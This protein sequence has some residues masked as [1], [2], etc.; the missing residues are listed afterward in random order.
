MIA[1]T[2]GAFGLE[3]NLSTWATLG[4]R[5]SRELVKVLET[6]TANDRSQLTWMQRK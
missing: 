4:E 2:T 6:R 5:Q 1:Y 3:S